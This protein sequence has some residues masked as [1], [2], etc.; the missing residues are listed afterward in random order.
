M[1]EAYH[2]PVVDT[3]QFLS[4]RQHPMWIA[5]RSPFIGILFRQPL[6]R[7]LCDTS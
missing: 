2:S 3:Q 7:P 1:V 5:E 6:G 4:F